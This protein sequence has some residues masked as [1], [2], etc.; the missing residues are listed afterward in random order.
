MKYAPILVIM[1]LLSCNSS[2]KVFKEKRET[3][4]T[5]NEKNV[6][7]K[8]GYEKTIDSLKNEISEWKKTS[9]SF[10]NK[11][12]PEIEKINCPN[13]NTDSVNSLISDLN[14]II[15]GQ[16]NSIIKYEDGRVEYRGKI[17]NYTNENK[18]IS[19]SYAYLIREK[20]S[21]INLIKEKSKSAT[22][23]YEV[24]YVDKTTKLYVV[25]WWV[26]LII[27][28]LAFIFLDSKFKIIG[29]FKKIIS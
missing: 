28:C 21:L 26:W 27:G 24:K 10:D 5:E 7:S 12:C 17:K 20:D 1:I 25:H 15:D 16:Q 2:K 18:N 23:L 4:I 11:P 22:T 19:S 29:W 14:K 6:D 3:A 8:S 9:V 13:F